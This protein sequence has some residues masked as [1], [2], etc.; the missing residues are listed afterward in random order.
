MIKGMYMWK[1][2]RQ[3]ATVQVVCIVVH[4]LMCHHRNYV[5]RP[6]KQSMIHKQK[7]RDELMN[8]LQ[9][10]QRCQDI[11]PMGLEAF[12]NLCEIPKGDGGLRPTKLATIEEQVAKILYILS[13]N[14]MNRAISF[15]FH[16]YGETIS[17]HFHRVLW[18]I[19]TLEDQFLQQPTRSNVSPEKE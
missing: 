2:S 19:I 12:K 11:I 4:W 16:L 7:V 14:V 15:F 18:S 9:T 17:R 1:Q 3:L 5:S 13:N 6:T 8:Q 10:N